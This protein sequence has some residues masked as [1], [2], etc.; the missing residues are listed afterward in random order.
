MTA[1]EKL[2]KRDQVA[3]MLRDL[4]ATGEIPRGSRIRQ[5]ELAARFDVSITP[6]REAIR[7]LHSEGLLIGEPRR[8]VRVA[9]V[10]ADRLRSIYVTRRVLET[11]ATQRASRRMSPI[12]FQRAR[13]LTGR[14]ERA[15][16][17]GDHTLAG[18]LNRDFHFVFY[19]A[20]GVP[21]LLEEI[22]TQWQN[23]PWDVT[24]VL[25]DRTPTSV[26]EHQVILDA[27]AKGDVDQIAEAVGNHL[28]QSYQRLVEHVTGEPPIADPYDIDVPDRSS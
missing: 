2:T 5:D 17:A 24:S 11:Y 28:W 26:V 23:F 7:L 25:P 4:I 27:V 15:Y 21:G 19:D 10:S 1:G 22:E 12:D 3:Q 18:S 13:E 8:G 16:A 20:C 14:M 6:I 9:S